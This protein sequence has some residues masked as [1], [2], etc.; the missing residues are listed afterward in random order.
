[1]DRFLFTFNMVPLFY[2]LIKR[3][4][5]IPA[6]VLMTVA[7][8]SSKR[9]LP[10]PTS[11]PEQ[12]EENDAVSASVA[13]E[14]QKLDY[15]MEI[16]LGSEYGIGQYSIKKW[17]TD[18]KVE[19][20]GKPTLEDVNALNKVIH[21]LNELVN[22]NLQIKRV[23]REG[24][25]RIYFIDQ[26]EFYRYEPRG[27][28]FYDGFFWTWWNAIGE[29]YQGRIVIA[30]N[31]INQKHRSHLIREELTQVLGL[32]NDSI[33]YKDSIFYQGYSEVDEF[34]PLD[35]AVIKL[36]YSDDIYSGM[37]DSQLREL[38]ASQKIRY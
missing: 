2:S 13:F 18:I 26:A 14:S 29:I 28:V 6:I 12:P 7:C 36:L 27:L 17:A 23:E 3:F 4:L 37:K 21:E 19:I 16:A 33:R 10:P 11:Q 38:L 30:R 9:Q 35:R 25:V 31:G 8:S 15:F 34:S 20:V 24:N 1:M 32:M 5:L 22:P